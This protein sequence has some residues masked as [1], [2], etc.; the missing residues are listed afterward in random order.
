MLELGFKI[1]TNCTQTK[2]AT[3]QYFHYDNSTRDGYKCWCIACVA[4]Y[5]KNDYIPSN[6]KPRLTAD[7]IAEIENQRKPRELRL[8]IKQA[9][10]NAPYA[11]Y[12][13]IIDSVK[14]DIPIKVCSKCAIQYPATTDYFHCR[15]QNKDGLTGCCKVCIAKT[16]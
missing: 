16:K 9:A 7:E 14:L 3:R 15:K 8:Q 4:S 11:S 10:K 1:C 2:P 5:M 6:E 12:G 13:I